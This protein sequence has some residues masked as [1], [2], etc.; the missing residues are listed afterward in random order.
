MVGKQFRPSCIM[1][2]MGGEF[3]FESNV[4]SANAGKWKTTS[5]SGW[6]VLCTICSASS[7]S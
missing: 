4:L 5:V 3:K 1:Y 6:N 7:Q 2:N